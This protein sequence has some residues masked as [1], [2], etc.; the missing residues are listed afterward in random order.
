MVSAASSTLAVG[1]AEVLHDLVLQ[2]ARIYKEVAHAA[3]YAGEVEQRARALARD[4]DDMAAAP[5]PWRSRT[6]TYARSPPGMSRDR[7]PHRPGAVPGG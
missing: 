2:A 1:L 6:P 5:R 7:R 4:L 3:A